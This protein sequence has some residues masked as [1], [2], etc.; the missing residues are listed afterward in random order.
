M[1]GIGVLTAIILVKKQEPKQDEPVQE[2]PAPEAPATEENTE[3]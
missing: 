2:V 3:E 1:I